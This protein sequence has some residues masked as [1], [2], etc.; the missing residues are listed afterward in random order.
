[1][2]PSCQTHAARQGCTSRSN[3]V[4][5]PRSHVGREPTPL[6]ATELDLKRDVSLIAQ[7]EALM[8]VAELKGVI[9]DLEARVGKIRDW[10]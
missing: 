9:S 4:Y 2:F 5:S 3:V 10:L 8:E 7:Y 1:M 6:S